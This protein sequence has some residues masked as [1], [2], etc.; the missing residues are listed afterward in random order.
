MATLKNSTFQFS[1]DRPFGIYFNDYFEQVY[2]SVTGKDPNDFAYTEG[3]TLFSTKYE[4]AI[5]LITYFAV[6]FGGQQFMKN[7][8]PI[9]LKFIFQLHNLLLRYVLLH[10]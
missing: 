1:L 4:V 10:F 9:N 6:I 7:F 8:S 3:I 2:A 5:A